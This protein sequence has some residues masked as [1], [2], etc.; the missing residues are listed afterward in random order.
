MKAGGWRRTNSSCATTIRKTLSMT[1]TALRTGEIFICSFPFTSGQTSK[2]RPVLVLRNLGIDCLIC[3]ITSA[4]H[5]GPLDI[6]VQ[7][8]REAGLQKP[9]VVRL[10]RLVTAEKNLLRHRIGKLTE[11]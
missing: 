9:S 4:P 10:T 11:A 1:S 2:P 7:R 5:T 8:W 3:R 6:A